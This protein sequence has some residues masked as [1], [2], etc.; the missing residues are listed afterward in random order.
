MGD[1]RIKAICFPGADAYR[2]FHFPVLKTL[3]VLRKTYRNKPLMKIS[4]E[5]L[6]PGC[7]PV[8]KV[9]P[10]ELQ[11]AEWKKLGKKNKLKIT[12]LLFKEK[13][14][15]EP[16]SECLAVVRGVNS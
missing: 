11:P 13:K 3:R 2:S 14:S 7:P 15:P 12:G 8:I 6:Q 5:R 4:V 10:E 16:F 9:Y 1:N